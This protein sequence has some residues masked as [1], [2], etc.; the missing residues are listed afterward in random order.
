MMVTDGMRRRMYRGGRPNS[1]ARFLN[2]LS[3]FQF[4]RAVFAPPDWITLEV[5]GRR[6]GNTVVCPLVVT[7]YQGERYLVSMLGDKA[8]WVANVRAANGAA[9][10]RHG[11]RRPVRLVEVEPALRA[12]ILQ[13]YLAV[14]PGARAHAE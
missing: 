6:S 14:A 10:L 11:R 12:P 7:R 5:I 3:A 13:R 2:R 1:V 4:G 8:N 9:V